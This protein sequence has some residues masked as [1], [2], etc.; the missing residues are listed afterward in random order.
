MTCLLAE[1]KVPV[2]MHAFF[3]AQAACF[4]LCK[5]VSR[6][7]CMALP[8][9]AGLWQRCHCAA[10]AHKAPLNFLLPLTSAID[11]VVIVIN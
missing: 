9:L 3:A 6:L 1:S 8:G 4:W 2:V 11:N 5:Y 7:M 10:V